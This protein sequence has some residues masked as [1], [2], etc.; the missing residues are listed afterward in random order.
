MTYALPLPAQV[1]ILLSTVAS[2]GLGLS[3]YFNHPV[4]LNQHQPVGMAQA[5]GIRL[6]GLV[7]NTLINGIAGALGWALGGLLPARPD[8]DG[9][10]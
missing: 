4:A 10:R 7:V 9:P 5:L 6:G 8:V 3:T 2:Y 1:V